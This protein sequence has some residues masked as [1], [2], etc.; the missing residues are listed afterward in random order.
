[1]ASSISEFNSHINLAVTS[2][3]FEEIDQ[4]SKA[5]NYGSTRRLK[6]KDNFMKDL[7]GFRLHNP[8]TFSAKAFGADRITV[9]WS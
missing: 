5:K 8:T 3:K 2:P 4:D 6:V 7:L 9:P 1:M